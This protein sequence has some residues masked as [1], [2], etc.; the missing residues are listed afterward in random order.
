MPTLF[1]LT[2]GVKKNGR[3]YRMQ[4]IKHQGASIYCVWGAPGGYHVSIHDAN[5]D[6]PYGLIHTRLSRGTFTQFPSGVDVG[7]TLGRMAIP[8]F[9]AITEPIPVLGGL[10]LGR[11]NERSLHFAKELDAR[12]QT[13][14]VILDAD[15]LGDRFLGW[16]IL[17]LQPGDWVGTE[18]WYRLGYA[19]FPGYRLESVHTWSRA[20]PW[21]GIGFVSAPI[22]MENNSGSPERTGPTSAGNRSDTEARPDKGGA[23]E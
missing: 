7:N 4:R 21:L 3:V 17:L 10:S 22:E 9:W 19:G 5:A 23:T 16:F 18:R 11:I 14:S 12:R 2:I 8:P 13:D 15:L 6:H 20:D 1:S